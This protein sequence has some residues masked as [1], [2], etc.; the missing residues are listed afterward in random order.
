MDDLATRMRAAAA[1]PPPTRIDLDHLIAGERRRSRT[2]RWSFGS[3]AVAA[4]VALAV[5]VPIFLTG[6]SPGQATDPATSGAAPCRT[7]GAPGPQ[8]SH[9]GPRPTE[10]CAEATERLAAELFAALN[11]IAP[12][13]VKESDVTFAYVPKRLRYESHVTLP[14]SLG[15]GVMQVWIIASHEHPTAQQAGCLAGCTYEVDSDGTIVTVLSDAN[16][17]EHQV[18]VYR[19]D[20]TSLLVRAGGTPQGLTAEEVAW[21]AR[22]P[23]LTLFPGAAA[24]APTGTPS[25]APS[26]DALAARLTSTLAQH[27]ATT[28]PKASLTDPRMPTGAPAP[29]FTGSAETGYKATVDVRDTAGRGEVMVNFLLQRPPCTT[30]PY[31][32]KGP[33]CPMSEADMSCEIAPDGTKVFVVTADSDGFIN[34]QVELHRPDGV[35][36]QLVATNH[37]ADPA[38]NPSAGASAGPSTR[39]QGIPGRIVTRPAPPLTTAQLVEIGN[40]LHR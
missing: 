33:V 15:G 18:S 24:V 1:D 30:Q 25:P 8:Q 16:V 19:S 32:E 35:I 40:A 28:L 29:W 14:A 3:A 2:L 37:M 22:T 34:H 23:G 20:G 4:A 27:L 9:A 7:A 38:A 11:K 21:I 5:S 12:G 26:Q 13:A 6:A 17:R 39:P 31:C 36:V 10:P